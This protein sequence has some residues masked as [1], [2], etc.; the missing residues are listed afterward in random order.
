[1]VEACGPVKVLPYR[2]R[3]GFMVRVRFTGAVP[4]KNWLDVGFWF[5]RRVTNPR[6]HKIETLYPNAHIHLL[7]ITQ[8][9][10]LDA[11]V[12]AWIKEAYAIGCQEHLGGSSV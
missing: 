3:I 8:P 6:F 1:M 2:D 4:R 11:E 10:Q 5:T 7:R 9:D 12:A